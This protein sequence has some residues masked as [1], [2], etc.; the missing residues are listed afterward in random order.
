M[1]WALI[2]VLNGSM[3]G[4]GMYPNIDACMHDAARWQEQ[5]VVAVCQKAQDPN[6]IYANM[7]FHMSKMLKL[8]KTMA[9][10]AGE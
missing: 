9:K 6:E 8:V 7:E 3:Q 4:M 2:V 10:D 5:K 1:N